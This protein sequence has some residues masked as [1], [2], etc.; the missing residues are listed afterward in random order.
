MSVVVD[1]SLMLACVLQ[2]ERSEAAVAVVAECVR[3]A[4]PLLAPF[5][6]PVELASGIE[7]AARRGRIAGGD[8]VPAFRTALE[9]GIDLVT[10]PVEGGNGIPPLFDLVDR[11]RLRVYGALYLQLALAR[12]VPLASLDDDLRR[13]ARA[14]GVDVLPAAEQGAGRTPIR[15]GQRRRPRRG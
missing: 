13:A 8:R 3:D 1:A 15:P 6:F 7:Q 5:H 9:P 4:Q 10:L 12:A 11:S 2:D 14:E